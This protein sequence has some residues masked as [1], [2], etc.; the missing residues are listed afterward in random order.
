MKDVFCSTVD[1]AWCRAGGA[2]RGRRGGRLAARPAARRACIAGP[3][4]RAGRTTNG[5]PGWR[6]GGGAAWRGGRDVGQA[7]RQAA[8]RLYWGETAVLGPAVSHSAALYT[9]VLH[10]ATVRLLQTQ[11][12]ACD[13]LKPRTSSQAD[14]HNSHYF[15]TA[16]A[17]ADTS[18]CRPPLLAWLPRLAILFLPGTST[19]WT[20]CLSYITS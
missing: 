3:G 5:G 14:R 11:G 10:C 18:W 2:G 7:G 19:R 13:D 8:A 6:A 12:F 1:K 15:R 17:V 4:R 20:P 16:A 9:L